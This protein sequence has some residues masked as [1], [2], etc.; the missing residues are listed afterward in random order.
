[1]SSPSISVTTDSHSSALSC[2]V[3]G[4]LPMQLPTIVWSFGGDQLTNDSA[5]TITTEGGN[6]M[7]QNGGDSPQSSI[8]SVLTISCPNKTHE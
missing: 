5:Y 2:E 3:Y 6:H 8:R 1:M 7:I 4:Y